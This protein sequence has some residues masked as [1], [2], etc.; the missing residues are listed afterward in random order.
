MKDQ[1]TNLNL[2]KIL[3][4]PTQGIIF[5]DLDGVWFDENNNF[6]SPPLS[7]AQAIKRAQ[8]AGY[9]VILVSDTGAEGLSSYAQELATN[10]VVIGENGAVIYLPTQ[11]I[12]EYLT[13]LQ[14]F[15]S[16]YREKAVEALAAEQPTAAIFQGDATSFIKSQAYSPFP[17][18]TNYLVNTTRECSFGVYTRIAD[19]KGNLVIDD[20]QTEQTEQI[21]RNLLGDNTN[22][23]ACKTYP[24]IGSC[25]VKD[26]T[27]IKPTA[28]DWFISQFPSS[29]FF[30]M[31]GDTIND[32]ME[33][34][35]GKVK[36]CAVGN[37]DAAL[38]SAAQRTQGIIAP[39]T[40][41][42]AR[43]ASYIIDRIIQKG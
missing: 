5:S 10:P 7:D 40:L 27:V 26:Q 8:E 38:K 37:A 25:L 43:G 30:Y 41:T 19:N 15:F 20:S 21:L 16:K 36:T 11:G 29:L 35:N 14:L 12:K 1:E 13:P 4:T 18:R 23:L 2:K 24:Q 9:W 33:G 39:D 22:N 28:V 17:G 3:G 31:I 34:L 6:S 42:I 32:S